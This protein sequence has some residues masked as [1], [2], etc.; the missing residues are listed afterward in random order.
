ML[1]TLTREG[2]RNGILGAPEAYE[3][4]LKIGRRV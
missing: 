2:V 4:Q 1:K 3:N